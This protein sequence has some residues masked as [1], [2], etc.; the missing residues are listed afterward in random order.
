[1]K[2]KILQPD[3]TLV[4]KIR[5]HLECHPITAKVLANRNI[6]TLSQASEYFQPRL[7]ILPSPMRL[8]GMAAATQRIHAGLK[9]QEKILVFGD[10]DADGV[11]ATALLVDFL[12][13]AGAMV[14]AHIPH[15]IEEGYGLQPKHINQIA[16]P[17]N[18]GLIITVDCGSS[19][20]E[21]VD[22]AKRFGIDVIITDHHN[23][24]SPPDALAVINPKLPGEPCD[25]ASLAGVGVAFYLTIGLRMVR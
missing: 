22:A 12:A 9:H 2:W 1:M 24:D 7:D 14:C 17:K 20:H 10:Y 25:L 11:T 6:S 15:R 23:I 13:S 4:Q 16:A 5:D 18:I 8:Q 19:S 3:L 21:A